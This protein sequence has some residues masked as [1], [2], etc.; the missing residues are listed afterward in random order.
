MT[1]PLTCRY[2]RCKMKKLTLKI[3]IKLEKDECEEIMP[4]DRKC[5]SIRPLDGFGFKSVLDGL[6]SPIGK[7][8]QA[9]T[10]LH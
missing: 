3:R 6:I 7:L 4:F 2:S 5:I 1:R 9:E 8:K 10:A